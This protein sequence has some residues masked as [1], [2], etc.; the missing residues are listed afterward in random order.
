VGTPSPTTAPW[1]PEEIPSVTLTPTRASAVP[2][3]ARRDYAAGADAYADGDLEEALEL[4]EG[5]LTL[6]PGHPDFL[7][8]RAAILVGLTRPLDAAA[9]LRQALGV[10]PYHAPARRS[11]AELFI[12]YGRFRDAAA[13]YTRYLTLSPDDPEGWYALGQI[14]EYQDRP[15]DAIAAYSQTL[16]LEPTHVDGL[17]RRAALWLEGENHRAA[18][19]DYTA[20]LAVAPSASAYFARARINLILDAPLLAAADLEAGLS[21][22]SGTPSYTVMMQLGQ[23]YLQGGAA[24]EAAEVFSRTLGLTASVEPHLWLGESYLAAGDYPAAAAVLSDI[25]PLVSPLERGRV[26]A[27]RGEAYL[28]MADYEAALSDLTE[29]LDYAKNADEQAAVL[30]RRSAAYTALDQYEEAIA[31]LTAA[32]RL[33]PSPLLLYR[34]GILNQGAGHDQAAAADLA[35]FLENADPEGTAPEILEDARVRLAELTGAEPAG[36]SPQPS[37][38]P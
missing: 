23:A 20:L 12:D 36:E 18:W 10:D 33:A 5:A 21:L 26:L 28:G 15:L 32:H 9:D 29:A 13:E 6:A 3:A 16:A 34:R 8:L 30:T 27:D 1:L 25:L 2:L 24:L 35:A 14:R 7:T 38:V 31:D 19:S 4:V 37:P 11:M 17:T 22:Q